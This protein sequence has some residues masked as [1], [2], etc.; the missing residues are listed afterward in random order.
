MNYEVVRHG[1]RRAPYL[2]PVMCIISLGPRPTHHPSDWLGT[3]HAYKLQHAS[4]FYQEKA[5]VYHS[6]LIHRI[7]QSEVAL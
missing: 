5:C 4:A 3:H 2:P 7:C 1:M 6:L